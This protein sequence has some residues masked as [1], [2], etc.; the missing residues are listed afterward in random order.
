MASIAQ[1]TGLYL[2]RSYRGANLVAPDND[3]S[4]SLQGKK[5]IG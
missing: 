4:M 2:F 3:G 5:P 1:G